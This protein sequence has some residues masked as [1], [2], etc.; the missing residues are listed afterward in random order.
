MKRI[1]IIVM[2]MVCA[3][4]LL[5]YADVYVVQLLGSV[6]ALLESARAQLKP[7][8]ENYA[9]STRVRHEQQFAILMIFYHL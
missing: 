7:L 8:T 3:A 1:S 4:A 9:V 6:Q 5:Y 2:F